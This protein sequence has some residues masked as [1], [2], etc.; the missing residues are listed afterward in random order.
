MYEDKPEFPGGSGDAKQKPSVGV[1]WIFS[2]TAH[3]L[4]D[5]SLFLTFFSPP[6]GQTLIGIE[7]QREF[8]LPR[9]KTEICTFFNQIMNFPEQSLESVKHFILVKISKEGSSF[10]KSLIP[11]SQIQMLFLL[12]IYSQ[13]TAEFLWFV[14]PLVIFYISFLSLVVFSLQMFYGREALRQLKSVSELMKK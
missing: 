14:V 11:T 1:V 12:Y 4:K 6:T 8:P 7:V 10:L 13:L 2:G 9:T 3:F 5:H